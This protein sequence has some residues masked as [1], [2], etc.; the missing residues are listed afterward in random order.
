MPQNGGVTM[1][2]ATQIWPLRE[3]YGKDMPTTLERIAKIGY[4]GV[5]LCRWFDWTD[6]F[7]KWTT[8]DIKHVCDGVDL[9]VVSAHVTYPLIFE[10]RIAELIQFCQT[11]DMKYVV[12]AAVPEEEA[13]TRASIL[14]VAEIFNQAAAT[15]KPEGI[16]I[17]YHNH[18]FDF[19]P[20][21]GEMPWDIFFSNT[22][23]D[24]V[25]QLDIGNA[26]RVGVD[27]IYYLQKYPGRGRL[28]HIKAF[29]S[30]GGLPAA[31]GDGDVNWEQMF[32]ICERLHHPEWYIV[33]QETRGVDTW[34][35]AEKSL[36][37]LQ[38]LSL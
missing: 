9:Q 1:K 28:L 22:D 30:I 12:V 6:M 26:L 23:P 13:K 34:Y 10:N 35:S 7:D 25:M 11:M 18:G 36:D 5:E 33:E 29:S 19:S 3:S 27:P 16:R 15:L 4:T 2:F 31:I 38:T 32:E 37:Y 24:V 20:I 8:E 14:G 21:D 17:G